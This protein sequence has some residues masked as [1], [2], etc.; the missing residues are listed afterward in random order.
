[1]DDRPYIRIAELL[2]L[3][4]DG[5]AGPADVA[6]METAL[7]NNPE[8][9]EYYLEA[10][11]DLNYFHSLSQ[12]PL[13]EG[14]NTMRSAGRDRYLTLLKDLGEYEKIAPAIEIQ[15][16]EEP[17]EQQLIQKVEYKRT[18]R[19][20]SRFSIASAVISAAAILMLVL[21]VHLVPPTPPEVAT[22]SKSMDA[23][24]SSDLPIEPG[25]PLVSDLKPIQLTQGTVEFVTDKLVRV[26]LEAPAEFYF[27]SDSQVSMEHGRLF[28]SVPKQGTGFTVE[29][30]NCK[31]IDLGT[32][33]TVLAHLEGDTEVHM[34]KGKAEL[35]AGHKD[36]PQTSQLLKAGSAR[37]VDAKTH[38]IQEIAL[39]DQ[40]M[41]RKIPIESTSLLINGGFESDVTTA[42]TVNMIG[43]GSTLVYSTESPLSGSYS[44]KLVTDWQ[45]GE[46]VKSEIMQTVTGLS[47][48]TSYDFEL[49]VKGLMDVGGVASAEIYWFDARRVELGS[50]GMIN[51]H[52]GLS[53]KAY[54]TYGGTYAT[55]SGT[56]SARISIRLE[57]GAFPALN[58][59]YVDDVSFE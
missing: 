40:T 44:A 13:S 7:S 50:T 54:Q 39:D 28:A 11:M 3:I 1:M 38:E 20:I 33:F 45:D 25:T 31:V 57:G 34:Y 59:L 42:W 35:F 43:E 9:L 52:Q 8:A 55:P 27:A 6:E 18:P 17:Q 41:V 48:S 51:L 16:S 10:A 32:E 12:V 24:W 2:L 4:Y 14:E 56:T 29:T 37:V 36:G 46:G 30:P 22:V 53:D 5:S 15:K 49:W 23:Q 58:M 21:Y 47:G 26:V 19:T